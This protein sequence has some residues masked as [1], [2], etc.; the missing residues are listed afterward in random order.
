M[1]AH[2]FQLI[3]TQRALKVQ[4]LKVRIFTEFEKLRLME[5]EMNNL[6]TQFDEFI[7]NSVK[8]FQDAFPDMEIS[9][10][11]EFVITSKERENG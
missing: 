6:E 1:T 7:S 2:E 5:Q 8:Q 4:S 9:M 11:P 3:A 10:T